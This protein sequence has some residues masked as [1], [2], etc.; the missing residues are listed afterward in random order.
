VKYIALSLAGYSFA[1]YGLEENVFGLIL[2]QASSANKSIL[3]DV[4]E[5]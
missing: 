4:F 2:G 3:T 5:E 1:E